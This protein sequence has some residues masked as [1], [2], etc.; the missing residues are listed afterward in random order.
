[1]IGQLIRPRIW[2]VAHGELGEL[3]M[4][5]APSYSHVADIRLV[6]KVLDEALPVVRDLV[7]SEEADA[8]LCTGAIGS[9][10]ADEI[11]LP[12]A[13]IE[14]TA[15]DMLRAVKAAVAVSSR[16][17]LIQ[18][19]SINAEL[20]EIRPLIQADLRQR[21]Y[22]DYEDARVRV[23][24]LAAE[25]CEVIVG[26]S[27][28][29][30]LSEHA[31]IKGVLLHSKT[32][33]REAIENAIDRARFRLGEEAR[34][35]RTNAIIEHLEEGVLTA[36]VHGI[37]QLINPAMERQLG[38]SA[39]WALG[40]PISEVADDADIRRVL[41]SGKPAFGHVQ[42]IGEKVA[43]ANYIPLKE[44][45]VADGIVITCQ[46][47]SD[48]QQADRRIRTHNRKRQFA[49]RYRLSDV[50]G[51]SPQI[52]E[53]RQFAAQFARVDSTV[54]ITGES[55]TGKEMFAQGIHNA[56]P[57][58]PF[59]FVAINCAAFP[60]T[61]LE[62][63]LFGY[64]EGAFTGSR[65]GGKPGL[66]ELAHQGTLFLDELGEMPLPV[67]AKLL[68]V[69]QEREVVR[70]G[71]A[72]PIPLDIRIIAA[73]HKDLRALVSEGRLREDLYFRINILHLPIPPLRRRV[74]DIALLTDRL[75]DAALR[76]VG[77]GA[78]VSAEDRDYIIRR[79]EAYGWPG[80]IRELEN[81]IER[82]IV[83]LKVSAGAGMAPELFQAALPELSAL[84]GLPRASNAGRA[85]LHSTVTSR[86]LETIREVLEK[87]NGNRAKTSALLGVSRTTLWRKLKKQQDR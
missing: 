85:T 48:I 67:Q 81:A 33:V 76:G 20:E 38:I 53:A 66:L 50:L 12:I 7:R 84:G 71:G 80:N 63:E 46:D 86:E 8:F 3:V 60:E 52:E 1:M 43:I 24:Q 72:D 40:K 73:T 5:A 74:G 28:I 10:I 82:L 2:A 77:A 54:L 55:G 83:T 30:E 69:L 51:R 22:Q 62:S 45:G 78:L 36:D 18:Y 13:Q 64:E 29:V 35:K 23:E 21:C 57:R 14:V 37:V 44:R 17:G 61:L 42:K 70:L 4:R 15:F 9:R 49:A 79:F 11:R 32:S 6:D 19:G 34:H 58:R 87:N 68:R 56:S 75:L 39:G 47:A 26:P 41:R 27:I 16:V 59:P 31:G 65:R 25:G